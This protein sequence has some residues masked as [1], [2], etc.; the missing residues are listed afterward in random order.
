M[1]GCNGGFIEGLAKFSCRAP[2]ADM[3]DSRLTQDGISSRR[4]RHL[5]QTG[6]DKE[7]ATTLDELLPDTVSRQERSYAFYTPE[8]LRW[9]EADATT[10]VAPRTSCSADGRSPVHRF[11]GTMAE[12][13][14]GSPRARRGEAGLRF[15]R[16]QLEAGWS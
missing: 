16:E 2:R 10:H 12:F 15:R 4:S 5:L 1:D 11:T 7:S 14:L 13:W 6:Q 3:G 8:V 9:I